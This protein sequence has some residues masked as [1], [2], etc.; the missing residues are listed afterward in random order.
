MNTDKE[1]EHGVEVPSEKVLCL[2]KEDKQLKMEAK[3]DHKRTAQQ[4]MSPL[5]HNHSPSPGSTANPDEHSAETEVSDH[6]LYY[7]LQQCVIPFI[8][9]GNCYKQ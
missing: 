4:L 6:A 9:F 8:S 3:G 2:A 5:D 7:W 1:L